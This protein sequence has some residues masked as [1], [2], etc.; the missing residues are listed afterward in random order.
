PNAGLTVTVLPDGTYILSGQ[1]WDPEG[2]RLAAVRVEIVGGPISGRAT[3]TDQFGQYALSGVS[4]VL[5]VKASQDGYLTSIRDVP[6]DTGRGIVSVPGIELAP[7]IPY[8]S[9]G[10]S[11]QLTF[12]A[13]RSCQLP[14]DAATRTYTAGIN[15]NPPGL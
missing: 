5:Q 12:R 3:M 9:L 2:R 15:Q 6:Q 4:G 11:Y 7:D 10:G 8:A 1:V 13:S 14:Q